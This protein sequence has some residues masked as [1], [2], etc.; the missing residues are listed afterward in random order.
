MVKRSDTIKT[1][2]LIIGFVLL[3]TFVTAETEVYTQGETAELQVLCLGNDGYCT[4]G[5]NCN[6]TVLYPNSS[7]LISNQLME[8]QIHEIKP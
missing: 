3:L 6:I 4:S 1:F 7:I 8:N 2:S 5:A